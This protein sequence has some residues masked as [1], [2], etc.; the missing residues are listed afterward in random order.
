MEW[1]V[2]FLNAAVAAELAALP[3]DI[4]ARFGRIVL[5]VS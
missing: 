4:R 2:T 3:A 1:T 5:A